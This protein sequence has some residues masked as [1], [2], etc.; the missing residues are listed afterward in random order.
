MKIALI[1]PGIMPIPPPGWGAL[2]ILIWDMYQELKLNHDVEIINIIRNNDN[3][4]MESTEYIK[5]LISIINSKSYDFV[6]I[7]YDVH[8]HILPH[9]NCKHKAI[10]SQYPFLLQLDRH[11]G[12][13]FEKTFNYMCKSDDYIFALSQK[14]IDL[15]IAHGKNPDKLIL[16]KNGSNHSEIQPC[17]SGKFNNKSVYIAKIEER[18]RQYMFQTIP[19][20]DFYGPCGNNHFKTLSCYKGELEHSQLMRVLPDYGNLVLLS[21]GEGTPLVVKEAL[22]AGLPIV[23][24]ECCAADLEQ[25][26]YIDI[27]EE[28]RIND[29]PYVTSI[30]QQNRLKKSTYH[31]EIREYALKHFSWKGLMETY[32]KNIE[33]IIATNA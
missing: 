16:C 3:D 2:E 25:K 6:H 9:L 29:L 32:V 17:E 31:S 7:H 30:I 33:Q 8:Y 23:V 26:P 22:M 4:S 18:K 27:I 28:N 13:D 5:Q 12:D 19:D 1:G 11:R 20:L 10:T 24:S 15:F 21:S 14:D